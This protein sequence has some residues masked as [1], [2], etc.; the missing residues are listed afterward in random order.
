MKA[1]ELYKGH[2]ESAIADYFNDKFEISD[3]DNDSYQY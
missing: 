1:T 2:K 3:D